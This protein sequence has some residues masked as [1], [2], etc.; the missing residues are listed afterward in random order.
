MQTGL[1]Q[2][3]TISEIKIGKKLFFLKLFCGKSKIFTRIY[4]KSDNDL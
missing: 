2:H 1:D 3:F 4:V